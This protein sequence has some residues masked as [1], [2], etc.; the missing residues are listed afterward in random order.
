MTLR[1][2]LRRA[3][4]TVDSPTYR[5]LTGTMTEQEYKKAI[6][7]ERRELDPSTKKQ[8]ASS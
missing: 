7:Q 1:E 8:A 3:K 4:P 2:Q 5:R 6:E